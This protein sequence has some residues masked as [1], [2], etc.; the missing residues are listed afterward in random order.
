LLQCKKSERAAAACQEQVVIVAEMKEVYND[1]E[2]SGGAHDQGRDVK[3]SHQVTNQI[4]VRRMMYFSHAGK[5]TYVAIH[6]RRCRKRKAS[7]DE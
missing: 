2:R 1:E 6:A 4:S 7:G 3:C 5:T